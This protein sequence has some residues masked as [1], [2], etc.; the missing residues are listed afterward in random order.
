MLFRSRLARPP[1]W[2]VAA[3]DVVVIR[4]PDGAPPGGSLVLSGPAR[5][6][7]LAPMGGRLGGGALAAGAHPVPAGTERIVIV[8]G[9]AEE[10]GLL[11]WH[12]RMRL[13]QLGSWCLL[14]PDCTVRTRTQRTRRRGAVVRQA[15]VP[16][17]P[18]GAA[19]GRLTTC[20]ERKIDAVAVLIEGVEADASLEHLDLVVRGA[21]VAGDGAPVTVALGSRLALLFALSA[22]GEAEV[23]VS[24]TDAVHVGGVLGTTGGLEAL[25]AALPAV[26]A[27]GG[28]RPMAR[29][30]PPIQ[31]EWRADARK[32]ER[33]G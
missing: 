14:G 18:L 9:A 6:V 19:P 16:A 29:L 3:G 10:A 21:R 30:G 8:G 4:H 12:D 26:L 28:L 23:E 25:R 32:E 20:F 33:D 22:P 1:S 11:G 24:T 27:G 15:W 31:A 17:G 5:V 7:F 2:E 13:A